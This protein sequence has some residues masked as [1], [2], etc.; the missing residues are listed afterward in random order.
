MEIPF[1]PYRSTIRASDA[2]R[3]D[4]VGH[5]KRHYTEG[6]LTSEELSERVDA[7]YGAVVLSQLEALLADL[8]G[9]PL[10]ETASHRRPA[11]GMPLKALAAMASLAVL[12]VAFLNLVPAELWGVLL[13]LGLPMVAMMLFMLLPIVLPLAAGAWF[14]RRLR[15]PPL[16]RARELPYMDVDDHERGPAGIWHV[17]PFARHGHRFRL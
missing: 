12:A 9:P 17:V 3:E 8:P 1:R 5:L 6:R 14:L 10:E 16:L 13:L 4:V 11:F 2:D 7:A 15:R